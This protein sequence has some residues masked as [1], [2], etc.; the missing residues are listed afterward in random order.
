MVTATKSH[1]HCQNNWGGVKEVIFYDWK[2][3]NKNEKQKSNEK[4][5]IKI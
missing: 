3:L 4:F 5:G 1:L 2:I